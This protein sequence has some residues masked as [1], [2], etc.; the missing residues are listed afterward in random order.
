MKNNFDD[1]ED[2]FEEFSDNQKVI[3]T[4]TINVESNRPEYIS[5]SLLKDYMADHALLER[6]IKSGI[7]PEDIA[8]D[9]RNAVYAYSDIES[10][11]PQLETETGT[12]KGKQKVKSNPNGS[13]KLYQP[14]DLGFVEPLLLGVVASSLGLLYFGYLYL[15]I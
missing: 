9:Y 10:G 13:G 7:I 11:N 4:E 8:K 3:T 14:L 12:S 1:L 15:M 6:D 2:M 5:E